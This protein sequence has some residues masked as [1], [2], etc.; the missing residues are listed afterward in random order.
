MQLILELEFGQLLPLLSS[1]CPSFHLTPVW[2]LL[3]APLTLPGM[4][5]VS[6]V[7]QP[8]SFQPKPEETSPSMKRLSGMGSSSP[9]IKPWWS[10]SH[11]LSFLCGGS[12]APLLWDPQK[13]PLA[14][15]CCISK[16]AVCDSHILDKTPS[17]L[18]TGNSY[19]PELIYPRPHKNV[20]EQ[21]KHVAFRAHHIPSSIRYFKKTYPQGRMPLLVQLLCTK[22]SH[23]L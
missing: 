6:P 20:S 10:Q 15:Y 4:N 8:H 19:F 21:P 1:C 2:P 14:H 12:K 13:S 7:H 9:S 11:M 5:P 17:L 3:L 16:T 18:I 22:T 23:L